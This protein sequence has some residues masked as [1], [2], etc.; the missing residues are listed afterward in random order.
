MRRNKMQN[1]NLFLAEDELE[2]LESLEAGEW[3]VEEVSPTELAQLK[4]AASYSK[5][6][7]KQEPT[8]LNFKTQDLASLKAKGKELGIDY[9]III[10]AL[11]HNYLKGEIQLKI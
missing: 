9:Q 7:L 3:Q 8:T 10:Q 1:D 2:L 6:L 11:V 5:S 4:E